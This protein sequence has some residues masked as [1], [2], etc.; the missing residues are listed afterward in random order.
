[1]PEGR[2]CRRRDEVELSP[3]RALPV[4]GLSNLVIEM[5]TAAGVDTHS[6]AGLSPQETK[7]VSWGPRSPTPGNK[8]R[9]LGTPVWR[10]ALPHRPFRNYAA[11][12]RVMTRPAFDENLSV[13][14]R[15]E[16][17][18]NAAKKATRQCP[19]DAYV[20][21]APLRALS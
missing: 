1:M 2:N 4:P 19:R 3:R 10:P 11:L 13:F 12:A 17:V 7:T 21:R 18:L 16:I 15:R 20:P 8:D 6:T 9:F 5:E 14:K